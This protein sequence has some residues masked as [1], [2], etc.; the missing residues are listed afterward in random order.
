MKKVF[1][2]NQYDAEPYDHFFDGIHG[3]FSSREAAQKYLTE[4]DGERLEEDEEGRGGYYLSSQIEE[5][6]VY[7]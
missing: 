2:V 3:I 4:M 6:I 1:V 7:D 5:W